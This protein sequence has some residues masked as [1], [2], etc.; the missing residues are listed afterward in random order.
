MLSKNEEIRLKYFKSFLLA[1][2]NCSEN[3]AAYYVKD[4]KQFMEY[5][6]GRPEEGIGKEEISEYVMEMNRMGLME[7]TVSRKISSIKN[8]Y[9][10][11]MTENM[12]ETN[13][14]E[15]VESP[16]ADKHL[17]DVLTVE[18]IERIL[19]CIDVSSPE[20]IRDRAILETLYSSGLRVSELCGL[21]INDIDFSEEFVRVLGKRMKERIVP[22]GESAAKYLS[23]Y[24]RSARNAY[25]AKSSD[26]LFLNRRGGRLSRMSIW[27]ILKKYSLK[28]GIDKH[29][30]PH[31][32]RHSFATHLLEGGADLRSV[33][34]MLGHSS[35]ATTEIYTH[36][37]R[38]YLK[39][40]YNEYHPRS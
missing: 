33:Q 20:G 35:I 19:S 23:E 5:F 22:L 25:P 32:L 24:I 2:R 28:S 17:P 11:L 40:I 13:P 29:I 31:I 15:T 10:F 21:K 30:H 7:T 16:K 34:E 18:E 14:A 8:Y 1:D 6:E 9:I 36:I 27:N 3:T 26:A 38:K 37:N 4:V 12:A 39:E